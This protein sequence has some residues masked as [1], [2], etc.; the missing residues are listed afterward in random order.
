M[1][2]FCSFLMA[3]V[4]TSGA[5]LIAQCLHGTNTALAFDGGDVVKAPAVSG[6]ALGGFQDFTFEVWCRIDGGPNFQTLFSKSSPISPL[7]YAVSVSGGTG[8]INYGEPG[9]VSGIGFPLTG[10]P[11]S[12]WR[13]IALSRANGTLSAYVDGVLSSTTA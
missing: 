4:L 1:K 10:V 7:G 2:F 8:Y 5:G 12:V 3:A 11:N 13:H 9:N 6:G